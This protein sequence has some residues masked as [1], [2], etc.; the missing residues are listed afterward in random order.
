VRATLK[1]TAE[2]ALVRSGL[3]AILRRR[4]RWAVTVLAY[5]NVVPDEVAGR[6][7]VGLHLPVSRFREQLDA[8]AEYADVLPLEKIRDVPPAAPGRIR[9][10]I[11]FDDA[12]R[13]AVTGAAAELRRRGL[14]ATIFVAPGILGGRTCWWDA[15]GA[16]TDA[17]FRRRAIED[18]AGDE[19]LVGALARD[20]G[21]TP[22]PLPP[23]YGTA[24][25]AELRAAACDPLLTLGSHGVTH[26]NLARLPPDQ[27]AI[28]LATSLEWLRE[29]FG[30]VLSVLA[31]PFG[32]W[33]PQVSEAAARGGYSAAC[34]STGGPMDPH[35]S[36]QFAI[37]RLS[38]PAG[39]SRDGFELALA[40][41]RWSRAHTRT[42]D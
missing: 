25:E 37:P 16:T 42:R 41:F 30:H 4:R 20:S 15:Y 9:V 27:V 22:A 10:A 36:P 19:E 14:P 6:G 3:A 5:H 8:L 35:S 28:E 18:C 39:L 32:R 24:T 29:R 13:G 33:S 38:I 26:R 11:T 7:D 2:R 17:A 34:L 21:L 1:H 40:G 31:Y 12:S 23:E